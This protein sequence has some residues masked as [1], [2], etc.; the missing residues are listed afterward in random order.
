MLNCNAK[1][2][3]S[4]EGKIHSVETL[5]ALDGP[6]LRYVVFLQGC[7]LRCLYCHNPDTWDLSSGTLTSAGA[8]AD[9]I[10]RYRNYLTGGVTLSG[11]EPLLQADFVCAVIRECHRRAGLHCAID[12]AGSV[13]LEICREAVDEADMLLLDIKAFDDAAALLLTGSDTKNA[14]ALLNYCEKT[15]KSVW[16][17]HVLVPG[18]TMFERDASGRLFER[19]E[20]FTAANRQLAAG[21]EKLSG[22]TC[23]ERTDLLPFHKMGEFKWDELGVPCPLRD[24]PEPEESMTAWSRKMFSGSK[25]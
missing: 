22:Y 3:G 14:W 19:E 10:L 11:G 23:I 9:D 21:A 25:P 24:T 1:D 4:A 7:R 17:R 16:I 15:H 18:I 20:D 2:C 12:T 8:L 5:G 6:G 13:P